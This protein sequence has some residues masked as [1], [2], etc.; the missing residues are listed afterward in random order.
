[1]AK[2]LKEGKLK[3]KE[4]IVASSIENVP[5]ALLGLFSGENFG[6]AIV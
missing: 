1:M 3:Y 4:H 2:L 5:E 6:K